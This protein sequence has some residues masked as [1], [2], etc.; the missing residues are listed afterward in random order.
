MLCRLHPDEDHWDRMG[1][2]LWAGTQRLVLTFEEFKSR[3]QSILYSNF[4][5]FGSKSK[6]WV[7]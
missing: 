2:E 1:C 4:N 5:L 3:L 7:L 6:K